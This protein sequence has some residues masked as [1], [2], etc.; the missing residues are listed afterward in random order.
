MLILPGHPLYEPTLLMARR[1]DYL[2]VE[3]RTGEQACFIAEESGL[4]RPATHSEMYDYL[5]GG[6]YDEVMVANG[7]LDTAGTD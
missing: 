4:L 3:N 6:E 1:P 5:Y 2:E 7:Y